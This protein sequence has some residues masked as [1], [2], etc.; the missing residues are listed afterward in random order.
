M[1]E[2]P[3][4]NQPLLTSVQTEQ[5]VATV[6]HQASDKI[7]MST[8]SKKSRTSFLDGDEYN[9]VDTMRRHLSI[10]KSNHLSI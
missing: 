2:Y 9:F 5:T 3:E 6:K 8:D 10:K 1:P 4:E 7:I